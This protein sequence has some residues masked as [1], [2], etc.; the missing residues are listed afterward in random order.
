[1][2][3][4]TN[5]TRNLLAQ[6]VFHQRANALLR[7]DRVVVSTEY[8]FLHWR[9]RLGPERTAL[10]EALRYLV[11]Q[12]DKKEA[13]LQRL[14]ITAARLAE[15]TGMTDRQVQALLKSEAGP[16]IAPWRRLQS[17][18]GKEYKAYVAD[19]VAALRHFIPRLRYA[20]VYD[21]ETGKTLRTGYILEIALDDP[22]LPEDQKAL[23]AAV[24]AAQPESV[25]ANICIYGPGVNSNICVYASQN[26][27]RKCKYWVLRGV[28]ANIC[29]GPSDNLTVTETIVSGAADAGSPATSQAPESASL[30]CGGAGSLNEVGY[31]L[32]EAP[33][34][35]AV[36][37]SEFCEPEEVKS[38]QGSSPRTV[39]LDLPLPQLKQR[40][41]A[42]LRRIR[43]V[44][45]QNTIVA[46][47][48][49][50]LLGLGFDTTGLPRRK[51]DRAD[52]ARVGELCKLF[53]AEAVLET[54]FAVAGRLP[55][56][57]RDPLAYLRVSLENQLQEHKPRER[58]EKTSRGSR[59]NLDQLTP[60][61]YLNSYGEDAV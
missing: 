22:L 47:F 6:P 57:T 8:F 41:L 26:E 37:P 13:S 35:V 9:P 25:N 55:E 33:E 48:I 11:T 20:S 58:A 39:E 34:V 15:M 31:S 28:N 42:D 2:P 51:P 60:E 45:T 3:D 56:G 32:P 30:V 38:L 46:Q 40:A 43:R 59:V 10:V 7:P 21:R 44:P 27:G 16:E 49:G 29:T 61:D 24:E 36:S 17:P 53:G 23:H 4:I 50:R 14:E 19:Q 52:H 54:T 1:M 18:I 5:E 12:I